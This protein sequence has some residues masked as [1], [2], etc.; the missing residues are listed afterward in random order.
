MKYKKI[1]LLLLILLL[2][3]II[4]FFKKKYEFFNEE[5]LVID[6]IGGLGNQLFFLA[7]AYEYSKKY[8]KKLVIKQKNNIASYGKNRVFNSIIYKNFN[9]INI[10]SNN[11]KILNEKNINSN[12][13]GNIILSTNEYFQDYNLSI[14]TRK[15]FIEKIYFGTE[16][17]LKKLLK[18]Y[19]IISNKI[20]VCIHIRYSDAYTPSDWDGI[21]NNIELA[22]IKKHCLKYYKDKNILIFSNNLQKAQDYFKNLENINFVKE[23]D[24]EELYIM[25]KCNIYYCSPS[26]FNWWG[27]YLNL[28]PDKVYLLWENNTKI[29]NDLY[30]NYEY[31]GKKLKFT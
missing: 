24:Y 30:K 15:D 1:L 12:L 23:K 27:I 6:F 26:T 16:S 4:V 3:L 25:S 19:N 2:F 20:S 10:E 18:K 17:K 28:D 29:R 21:Y 13:S 5:L 14:K 22:K 8:N 7:A 11:F 31:L 9:I